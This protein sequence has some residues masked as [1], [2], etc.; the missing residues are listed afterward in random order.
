MN[1]FP[2]QCSGCQ[3]RDTGGR[4]GVVERELT[5]CLPNPQRNFAHEWRPSREEYPD[6]LEAMVCDQ[7]QLQSCFGVQSQHQR[8][9]DLE[10]TEYTSRT[11]H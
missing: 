3:G 8:G 4:G 1:P 5:K 6:C 9:E 7:V 10:E 11:T 2:L